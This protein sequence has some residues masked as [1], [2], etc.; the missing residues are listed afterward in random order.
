MQKKTMPMKKGEAETAGPPPAFGSQ[1]PANWPTMP[2]GTF[3]GLCCTPEP[4]KLT[5]GK[6]RARPMK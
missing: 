4:E 5:D 6:A 3:N 2:N 1:L